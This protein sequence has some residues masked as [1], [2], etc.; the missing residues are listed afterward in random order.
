M[1]QLISKRSAKKEKGFSL[2][3]SMVA[4]A[5]IGIGFTGVFT[6]TAVSES[7]TQRTIAKQKL[8]MFANQILDVIAT[9]TANIAS[10]GFNLE[11][12]TAAADT[13][14]YETR[15]FEWCT[16]LSDELGAAGTTNNRTITVTTSTDGRPAV[17]VLLES[18]AGA[19]QIVMRRTYDD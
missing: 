3:E 4:S 9:D 15:R 1:F 13:S 2:V 17:H 6:L 14:V 10:Y 16:R 7:F 8:Q 12:C 18:H 5:I 19:V 11:T